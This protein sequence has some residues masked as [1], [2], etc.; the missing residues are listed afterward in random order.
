M[1]IE[2]EGVSNIYYYDKE[3][4]VFYIEVNSKNIKEVLYEVEYILFQKENFELKKIVI[5]NED[6]KD[7]KM[8]TYK[9]SYLYELNAKFEDIYYIAMLFG[10]V[11]IEAD[12]EG[13]YI[14]YLLSS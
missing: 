3:N 1:W 6:I 5:L 4:K 12:M 9:E 11:I 2:V 8:M 10:C 7:R 13:L 14:E